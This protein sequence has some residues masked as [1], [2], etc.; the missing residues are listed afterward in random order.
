MVAAAAAAPQ[1]R[2]HQKQRHDQQQQAQQ[3]RQQQ[4]R[5]RPL[6]STLAAVV[7]LLL[8]LAAAPRTSA[9]QLTPFQGR[10]APL[11][12]TTDVYVSAVVD[13][14]VGVDDATYRFEVRR[15][16]EGRGGER[17]CNRREQ[18]CIRARRPAGGRRCSLPPLG[19]HTH[20]GRQ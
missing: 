13:H 16:L 20:A 11:N 10:N 17:R 3:R 7:A 8:A 4:R 1:S 18:G 2:Q 15:A 14:L 9:Q 6:P 19:Q 12:G 5:P